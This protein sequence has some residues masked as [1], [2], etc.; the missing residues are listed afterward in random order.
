MRIS[1]KSLPDKWW[2]ASTQSPFVAHPKVHPAK[3]QGNHDQVLYLPDDSISLM[4]TEALFCI[5]AGKM[6][7]WTWLDSQKRKSSSDEVGSLFVFLSSLFWK[8]KSI[9]GGLVA[10]QGGPGI[11]LGSV[12]SVG[13]SKNWHQTSFLLKV[14]FQR[15]VVA[16]MCLLLTLPSQVDHSEDTLKVHWRYIEDTLRIHWG[17]QYGISTFKRRQSSLYLSLTFWSIFF[18]SID[19]INTSKINKQLIFDIWKK[20][21]IFRV[22]KSFYTNTNQFEIL[23]KFVHQIN[24]FFW[25]SATALCN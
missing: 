25:K 3:K 16:L 1:E 24:L 9:K 14:G 23:M 18:S 5:F 11:M 4:T 22:F 15:T 20:K 17:Q 6:E 19:L 13:K 2:L 8:K 12:E 7:G 21:Q 10:G